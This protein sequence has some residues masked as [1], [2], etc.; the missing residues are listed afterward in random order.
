MRPFCRLRRTNYKGSAADIY[1]IDD[2]TDAQQN[3]F[4]VQLATHYLPNLQVAH[5]ECGYGCSDHASWTRQ[6]YAASF[7]FEAKFGEDN[8][9]IH[10]SKDTWANSGSQAQHAQKFTRLAVAWL[11]ELSEEGTDRIFANDFEI[12][13]L[14]TLE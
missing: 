5:T 4:M 12:D 1:I 10:S 8:P 14:R 11:V 9:W 13:A 2:D 6:G 3:D 7:P